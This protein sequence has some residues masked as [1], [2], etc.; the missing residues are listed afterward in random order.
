MSGSQQ[1]S[2]GD[3]TGVQRGTEIVWANVTSSQ[4]IPPLR[5]LPEATKSGKELSSTYGK[6]GVKVFLVNIH[7][8]VYN[9]ISHGGVFE[10][11]CLERNHIFPSIHDAVLF[12]QANAREVAPGHSFQGAPGDTELSLY[13][14]EE[15]GPSY[16]DLEQE[17]FGSMFHAETLTAL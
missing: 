8:Q 16:W 12:A 15:D 3:S 1:T 7:A 17:M 2:D 10:D 14:S 9:D 6:I 11:G 5:L 13:D 4:E